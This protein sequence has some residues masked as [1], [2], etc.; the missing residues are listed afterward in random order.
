LMDITALGEYTDSQG[1]LLLLLAGSVGAM[2]AA[3]DNGRLV[4]E[5]EVANDLHHRPVLVMASHLHPVAELRGLCRELGACGIYPMRARPIPKSM[6]PFDA[7]T[8]GRWQAQLRAILE[9]RRMVTLAATGPTR[10][11]PV[12]TLVDGPLHARL[13]RRSND[14]LPLVG[15]VK[16]SLRA[17]L[18]E[19]HL[20]IVLSLRE[21]ERS[22]AFR[23]ATGLTA[24]PMLSWYVKLTHDGGIPM[25]GTVRLEVAERYARHASNHDL[26]SWIDVMSAGLIAQRCTDA[27][28]PSTHP[29]T[30]ELVLLRSRLSERAGLQQH[31]KATLERTVSAHLRSNRVHR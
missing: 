18:P 9:L 23:V 25:A 15:L 7:L 1:R 21:G 5:D 28:C 29:S 27:V 2:A 31:L 24:G 14:E 8:H 16:P 12:T 10:L 22:P 4:T 20:S 3:V 11:P 6:S 13:R 17:Q 26:S 30:R 19:W